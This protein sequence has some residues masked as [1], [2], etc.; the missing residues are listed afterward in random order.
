MREGVGEVVLTLTRTRNMDHEV[1]VLCYTRAD[2]ATD[3]IDFERLDRSS[4]VSFAP[5]QTSAECI[6]TI[7]DDTVYEGKERFYVFMAGAAD[8]LVITALSETP[9]CIYILCDS[10]DGTLQKCIYTHMYLSV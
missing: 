4:V 2:T 6:V 10:N 1:S 7:H 9:L 8:S 3:N 5:N